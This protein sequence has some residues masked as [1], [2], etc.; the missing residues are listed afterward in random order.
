[1]FITTLLSFFVQ[2]ASWW[3]R[4]A[5]RLNLLPSYQAPRPVI[6]IGNI[7]F[8]GTGKTPTTLALVRAFSSRGIKAVVLTRGYR[9]KYGQPTHVVQPNDPVE[10]VGDEPLLLARAGCT[11][12]VDANRARSAAFAC[13]SLRADV[14]LLDDGFSHHRLRR[15][16]DLV[17]LGKEHLRWF[18]RRREPRSSLRYAN[19]IATL[20]PKLEQAEVAPKAPVYFPRVAATTSIAPTQRVHACAAI[21]HPERFVATLQ[22]LGHADVVLHAFPDHHPFPTDFLATLHQQFPEDAI[23]VT[24]KDAMKL[25]DIPSFVH[26]VSIEVKIPSEVVDVLASV[27]RK[28]ALDVGNS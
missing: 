15:D 25:I 4:V 23:A 9:R 2:A 11:V 22:G 24:E 28:P 26:V 13:R 18:H 12:V 7:G 21:A 10:A 3:R 27:V 19:L 5:H 1:M 8:G 17:L 16:F 6:S 20:E 14:L